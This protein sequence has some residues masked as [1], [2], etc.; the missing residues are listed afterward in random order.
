M[1]KE[2]YQDGKGVYFDELRLHLPAKVSDW[3][4]VRR[5]ESLKVRSHYRWLSMLCP[6]CKRPGQLDPH[7]LTGGSKGRSDEH[8]NLIGLCRKCHDEIQSAPAEYPRV[9]RAKWEHDRGHTD[10]VRL[11]LLLGRFPGF[12]TLD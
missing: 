1:A 11:V 8:A 9:W 3:P 7:H 12:D 10:W 6:L 5:V 4:Q 2:R